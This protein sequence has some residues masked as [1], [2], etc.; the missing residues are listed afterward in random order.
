MKINWKVRFKN[1][2]T[3]TAIVAG[4]IAMIYQLLNLLGITPSVSESQAAEIAGLFI[5]VLVLAGIVIDPT[6]RGINDSD[7]AMT[8][9]CPRCDMESAEDDDEAV[10]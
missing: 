3:V 1:K 9:T 2:G 5:N 8:Y 7:N 4:M 6:T 10:M